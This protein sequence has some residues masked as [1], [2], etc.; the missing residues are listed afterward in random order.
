MRQN[1]FYFSLLTIRTFPLHWN[2]RQAMLKWLVNAN[3]LSPQPV[4]HTTGRGKLYF[5]IA[6]D[7]ARIFAVLCGIGWKQEAQINT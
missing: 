3:Q 5:A 2:K 7:R 4:E 1:S 6:S